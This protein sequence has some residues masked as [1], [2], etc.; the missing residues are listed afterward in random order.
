MSCTARSDERTAREVVNTQ[1]IDLI[2]S[3][4][5]VF[6][7]GVGR[8]AGHTAIVVKVDQLTSAD[9]SRI[10]TTMGGYPVKIVVGER[11]IF[12]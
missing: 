3:V 12:Y 8:D 5:G 10:P 1:G 2:R 6:E 9:R 7:V 11:R 4:R